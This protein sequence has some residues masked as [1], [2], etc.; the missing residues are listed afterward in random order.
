MA[1][2]L[3]L[4]DA[5]DEVPQFAAKHAKTFAEHAGPFAKRQ[6]S[7]DDDGCALVEP[8][9]EVEQQLAA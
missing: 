2:T 4:D 7:G 1:E 9:D 3:V 6:I 5:I 8:A